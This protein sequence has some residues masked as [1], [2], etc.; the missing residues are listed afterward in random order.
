MMLVAGS[1]SL[2]EF[3][4]WGCSSVGQSTCFASRGSRVRLPS[5]PPLLARL[6]RPAILTISCT[7]V[8]RPD[9]F[10]WNTTHRL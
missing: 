2:V 9:W 10:L 5:A 4:S 3:L 8:V 1:R 6:K 7:G